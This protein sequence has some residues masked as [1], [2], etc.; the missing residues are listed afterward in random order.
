MNVSD[1][2]P[3]IWTDTVSAEL[4]H[5]EKL[6]FAVVELYQNLPQHKSPVLRHST[7]LL[8]A[9]PSKSTHIQPERT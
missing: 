6:Q 5:E 8:T 1:K 4:V 7:M 3:I 2:L 9:L